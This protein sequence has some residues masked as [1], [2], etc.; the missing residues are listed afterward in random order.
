MV[1]ANRVVKAAGGVLIVAAGLADGWRQPPRR[2]RMDKMPMMVIRC[3]ICKLPKFF[4]P[5]L[6]DKWVGGNELIVLVTVLANDA[7]DPAL[8]VTVFI[9]ELFRR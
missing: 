6:P 8:R 3:F 2:K 7:L 1:V 5:A 4:S 9:G